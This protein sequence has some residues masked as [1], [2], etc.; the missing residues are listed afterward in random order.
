[1]TTFRPIEGLDGQPLRQQMSS[2]QGA[3]VGHGG[4]LARWSPGLKTADAALLPDLKMGNAR[5]EDVVRNNA[6]ASNGVQLHVDNIVGDNFRLS[7]KPLW[8][9]LGVKEVEALAFIRDVEQIWQEVAE[10]PVGCYLDAERKRTF[11]M[12]MR[13]TVSVHTRLG[14]DFCSAEWIDRPGSLIHTA[15]KQISPKRISNPGNGA[16]SDLVRGGVESDQYGAAL[17]YHIRQGNSSYYGMGDG[18]GHTW[19]RV[20]RDTGW[21]R[22]KIIHTFEPTEDGQTRGANQF[23]SVL[24]QL[25]ILPK[26][27]HT[28]LQNAIVNA[29]YAVSLESDLGPDAGAALIGGENSTEMLQKYMLAINEFRNGGLNIGDGVKALQLMPNE[30]LNLHTSGNADNGY[31]QLESGVLGWIAAGLN[32]S[33]EGLSKDFTKLSYSTARASMLEQ[34][35][36]F[37]GR[38]KIIPARKGAVIFSLVLEDLLHSKQ[39]KL[40]KGATRDFYQARGAW[41]NCGFIGTG[42]MAI[43]GLKDVKEAILRVE[44]GFST[45]EKEL[46]QM[47]QDYQEVFKQQVREQ[48]EREAAGLPRPAWMQV[49]N[50]AQEDQKAEDQAAA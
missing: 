24:E 46:A 42:R 44:Y 21:G 48:K 10:D 16:D 5:A 25:Q 2:Y 3:G 33:K 13:E 23:L 47:G 19:K 38:R 45:Y 49:D 41:C 11:T 15:I 22:P 12:I 18:M 43:D 31:T 28:T 36:Y 39:L 9:S 37:M 1:M 26:L 6:F 29:M 17:A 7:Y 30:R 34:W 32:L 27:H 20:A 4:Q 35:R 50:F 14:E 8:E 40:P